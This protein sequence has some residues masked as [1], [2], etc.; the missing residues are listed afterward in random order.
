[1]QGWTCNAVVVDA[2]AFTSNLHIAQRCAASQQGEGMLPV[3]LR[4]CTV[5]AISRQSVAGMHD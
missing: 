5:K 3:Q 1:M 2:A 4:V